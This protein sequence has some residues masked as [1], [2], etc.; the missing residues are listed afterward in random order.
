MVLSCS[1]YFTNK[2]N[3]TY[4][5]IV[6]NS[7]KC[8]LLCNWCYQ[9]TE[10]ATSPS[11]LAIDKIKK[12]PDLYDLDTDENSFY[13]LVVKNATVLDDAV[14]QCEAGSTKKAARVFVYGEFLYSKQRS[15]HASF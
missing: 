1:R 11:L 12:Y 5:T 4:T 3:E 10:G 15:M 6:A 2:A 9:V 8:L 13:D 7:Y 14:F